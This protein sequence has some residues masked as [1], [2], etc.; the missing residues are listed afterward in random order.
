MQL[1]WADMICV[2]SCI[3]VE[4]WLASSLAF[5][6]VWWRKRSPLVGGENSTQKDH[7][8]LLTTIKSTALRLD[9]MRRTAEPNIGRPWPAPFEAVPTREIFHR[10]PDVTMGRGLEIKYRENQQPEVRFGAVSKRLP[11]RFLPDLGTRRIMLKPQLSAINNGK[12]AS[13]VARWP[14]GKVWRFYPEVRERFRSISC[15]AAIFP[16]VTNPDLALVSVQAWSQRR[17]ARARPTKWLKDMYPE[18]AWALIPR[19]VRYTSCIC[20]AVEGS[21]SPHRVMLALG[22]EQVSFGF[23]TSSPALPCI[24]VAD[25]HESRRRVRGRNRE[26]SSDRVSRFQ[27]LAE[28]ASGFA[29]QSSGGSLRAPEIPAFKLSCFPP[30][31]VEI[32][33][34]PSGSSTEL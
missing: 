15:I 16:L 11:P 31:S 18:N 29:S 14:L 27:S 1:G 26:V 2:I 30:F 6:D 25:R 23:S 8:L 19:D 5:S 7:C 24:S 28:I 9:S 3:G 10:Q 22:I 20:E 21:Q 32:V 34:S 13:H 4:R 17:D 33:S 12:H